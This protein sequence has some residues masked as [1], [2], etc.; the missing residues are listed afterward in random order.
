MNKRRLIPFPSPALR[1][2]RCG[3]LPHRS[4][5]E[6]A[7]WD[8]AWTQRQKITLDTADISGPAGETTVLVRLSEGRFK[9]AQ[10]ARTAA[11]SAS[12]PPTA[13]P[14]STPGRNL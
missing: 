3:A 10:L 9:F 8:K 4:R 6:D 11:T 5:A 1:H 14:S 13:R 12:S 2:R 7:W